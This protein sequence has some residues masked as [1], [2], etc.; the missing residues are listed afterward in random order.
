MDSP[1]FS[2]IIPTYNRPEF[3]RMAVD[4]V[5]QQGVDD[6]ECIVVDDCGPTPVE[7]ISDGRV[8]VV[9][10]PSNRGE[11]GARNTGLREARGRYLIFLDDDDE[12]TPDRLELALEGL[13]SAPISICWRRGSDGTTGGNR[14][15]NG[16]IH[17]RI[18]DDLIPQLGQVAFDRSLAPEFDEGYTGGTDTDWMLRLVERGPVRTFPRVGLVYRVHDGVRHGNDKEARLWGA[19]LLLRKH[20]GY[21]DRHP[22]AAAFRWKRIGLLSAELGDHGL[23]RRAFLRSLRLRPEARTAWHLA[24]S[25]RPTLRSLREDV[26]MADG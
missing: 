9:R 25:L 3:V 2:V 26:V 23:A 10:H 11:A 4:S 13:R 8:R 18:L 15:L 19:F 24:R 6:L 1:L 22:R 7:P 16:R 5:L 12:F 17:D 20:A 14:F 21:F